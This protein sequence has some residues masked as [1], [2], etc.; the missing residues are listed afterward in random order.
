MFQIC[1]KRTVGSVEFVNKSGASKLVNLLLSYVRSPYEKKNEGNASE[2]AFLS[3]SLFVVVPNPT[4][5]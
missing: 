3:L 4:L 2:M 5:F 1:K